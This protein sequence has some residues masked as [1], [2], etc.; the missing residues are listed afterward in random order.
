MLPSDSKLYVI[1]RNHSIKCT[2]TRHYSASLTVHNA[3]W[4]MPKIKLWP[5]C[6]LKVTYHLCCG[7]FTATFVHHAA[8]TKDLFTFQSPSSKILCYKLWQRTLPATLWSPHPRMSII[9]APGN[10]H[11]NIKGGCVPK[12]LCTQFKN[13]LTQKYIQC[14]NGYMP[15][16]TLFFNIKLNIDIVLLFYI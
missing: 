4:N 7:Y 1:W 12:N 11:C 9:F 8:A 16:F 15:N 10:S 5:Y 2:C 13:V 6:D 14:N 3:E